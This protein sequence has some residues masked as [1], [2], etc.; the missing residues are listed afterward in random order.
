MDESEIE[1]TA[2]ERQTMRQKLIAWMRANRLLTFILCYVIVYF[3]VGLTFYSIVEGWSFTDIIY[4]TTIIISSVGYGDLTPTSTG[5][6]WFTV[7]YALSGVG[8]FTFI[9][10]IQAR[11]TT[12]NTIEQEYRHRLESSVEAIRHP[13]RRRRRSNSSSTSFCDESHQSE[14][15][16]EASD[17][18]DSRVSRRVKR[19][20]VAFAV[21]FSLIAVGTMFASFELEL[22]FT[23]SVYWATITGTSIGFGDIVPSRRKDGSD[24]E[25][26]KWFATFYIIA[27]FMFMLK[28]LSWASQYLSSMMRQQNVKAA[29]RMK[30]SAELVASM[31]VDGVRVY[32]YVVDMRARGARLACAN[33]DFVT[34]GWRCGS[35]RVP[36]STAGC[37]QHCSC[38]G[39]QGRP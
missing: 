27:F 19:G 6:K 31:D 37:Q 12:S 26:G 1:L 38:Q 14:A 24:F 29:L 21:L 20:L 16:S 3:V 9:L 18:S 22:D 17:A 39:C 23:D 5:S 32:M 2:L 36:S 7:F 33:F 15:S 4:F 13:H 25:G 35:I 34:L 11:H 30:L 10:A 8:L 28:S